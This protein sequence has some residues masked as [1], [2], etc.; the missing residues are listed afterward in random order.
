MKS[1]IPVFRTNHEA[2]LIRDVVKT[3]DKKHAEKIAKYKKKDSWAVGKDPEKTCVQSEFLIPTDLGKKLLIPTVREN[4]DYENSIRIY[5]ELKH[6]TRRQASDPS[7]WNRLCHVECWNY[8]RERW[9]IEDRSKMNSKEIS[10]FILTRY[11]VLQRNSR[12]F[13][14]NGIA[15]LYWFGKLTHDAPF[16]HDNSLTE[17]LLSRGD[18][19]KN[20]L[21][22]SYGRSPKILRAILQFLK[23]RWDE[24][25]GSGNKGRNRC[26]L[27]FKILNEYGGVCLLDR[28]S[29]SDI[30]N[31]LEK[32]FVE[33][34]QTYP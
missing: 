28:L 14:R 34:V 4:Y 17:I 20:I 10:R 15:S 12:Y 19:T 26:R 7:L 23:Y 3:D 1:Y 8:M 6:L 33:A 25:I 13:V 11:F 30:K 9:N 21:E 5:N 16:E 32:A 29:D 27:L 31:V 2:R 18:I 22:R 24:M